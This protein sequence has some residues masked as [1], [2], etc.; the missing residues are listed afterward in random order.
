VI[1]CMW[2]RRPYVVSGGGV[3]ASCLACGD[4]CGDDCDVWPGAVLVSLDR[5]VVAFALR[6]R[7]MGDTPS[8]TTRRA[9]NCTRMPQNKR[10]CTTWQPGRHWASWAAGG[11]TVLGGTGDSTVR[12]TRFNVSMYPPRVRGTVGEQCAAE[13]P[14]ERPDRGGGIITQIITLYNLGQTPDSEAKT[15]IGHC[16][17]YSA[18][19]LLHCA[20]IAT[21]RY[22][23]G[24]MASARLR[25]WAAQP[26]KWAF[27]TGAGHSAAAR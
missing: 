19:S 20:T 3:E 6:P 25:H 1:R 22:I 26:A 21:L 27:P 2:R 10:P 14:N 11:G 8:P 18:L 16:N 9:R 4:A 17:C 23:L 7:R 13:G 15:T 5:V 24:Y 12:G